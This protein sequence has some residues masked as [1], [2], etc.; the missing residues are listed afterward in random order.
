MDGGPTESR[1]AG[2][3]LIIAGGT[4]ELTNH[5]MWVA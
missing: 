5:S 3:Q 1:A 4:G 2:M